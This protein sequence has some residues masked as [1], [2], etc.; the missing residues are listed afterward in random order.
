M[1]LI[2]G[3][4]GDDS[5]VGG[6]GSD[7]LLG[8]SGDDALNGGAGTDIL[9]G[10][11][12]DDVLNGGAGT[13][14]LYGGNGSDTLNGG[15]G[16]DLLDG[17]NGNDVLNGGTGND[18]LNGGNGND[19]LNG[20]SG[21]DIL[22]GQNG[23]DWLIY[24][25]SQ[26][27]G[28]SDYY[29]AGWGY[30]TLVLQLTYGELLLQSVQNDITAFRAFLDSGRSTAFEFSSFDLSA[31]GFEHLRIALLNNRPSAAADAAK[32]GEDDAVT[33]GVLAN[34]S[35][36]DHLD[37][38]TIA[39]LG[40]SK[41]GATI[42]Y[43]GGSLSYDPGSA[44]QWLAEGQVV[45]DTFS[46]TI[47]DLGGMTSTATV[48]V[49]VT[50]ENDAPTLM[51]ALSAA[52]AQPSGTVSEA[53]ESVEG[54][55]HTYGGT[56][57]FDD[58]DTL[59]THTASAAP[60]ASGY[61]GSLE[62]IVDN[63]A[64]TVAWSFTLDD[65][66]L[67]HL[68][69]N[70]VVSQFY[71]VIIDD[72]RAQVTQNVEI[73]LTGANDAPTI[74]ATRSDA[75]GTVTEDLTSADSGAIAF[76]DVDLMDL[77]HTVSFLAQG[78]GYRGLF[79]A[80]LDNVNDMVNWAFTVAPGELNDLAD[81]ELLTQLYSVIVDDGKGGS[82]AQTV[83][84]TLE[85]TNDA[86]DAQDD[87]HTVG[88]NA[89]AAIAV[90]ANDGDADGDTLTVTT[91]G[92]AAHG[93]AEINPDGTIRY[94]PDAGFYGADSFTYTVIDGKGGSDT[95]TVDVD[96]EAPLG[97]VVARELRFDLGLQYFMRAEGK[98]EWIELDSFQFGLS[99]PGGAETSGTD[100]T[101]VMSS[102]S[103]A[104][105]LF[106]AMSGGP[107]GFV[108]IEVYANFVSGPQLVDEFR[109]E[110]VVLTGHEVAGDSDPLNMTSGAQHSIWLSYAKIGHTLLDDDGAMGTTLRL[111]SSTTLAGPDA[112][113]EGLSGARETQVPDHALEF[114]LRVGD[115][116]WVPVKSYALGDGELTVTLGSSNALIKA[117]EYLASGASIESAEIEVYHAGRIVDEFKLD[118][119][120][121]T[122]LST[123]NA[124][125]F[126]PGTAGN[127][128][129]LG[130]AGIEYGHQ[131][132]GPEG[133]VG[134]FIGHQPSGDALAQVP[135]PAGM[136]Y[137]MR[138]TQAEAGP[139]GTQWI[140]LQEFSFGM[141]DSTDRE[142]SALELT[143]VMGA[144]AGAAKLL[145]AAIGS[146]PVFGSIEIE[147]YNGAMLVDE[148]KFD[149]VA[150]TGYD[151]DKGTV[152]EVSFGYRKLGHT[153]AETDTGMGWDFSAEGPSESPVELAQGM[154]GTKE[155]AAAPG[156]YFLKV[157]T[158]DG[159]GEWL[160]LA[161][162]SLGVRNEA[163]TVTL[164]DISVT[165]GSSNELVDLTLL[166][167]EGGPVTGAQIEVYREDG[168][169]IDEFVFDDV[170]LT[171]LESI[172]AAGNSLTF[173][174]ATFDYN[175][176][177]EGNPEGFAAPRAAEVAYNTSLQYFMKAHG[178]TDWI[179][180]QG[181][182]F[183]MERAG[184][185]TSMTDVAATMSTGSGAA[186]L[187]E[188]MAANG[189]ALGSIEIEAYQG[190]KL[191]DEFA[192][193]D[194]QLTRHE[195]KG[196]GGFQHPTSHS[197]SFDFAE[198]GHTHVG[199]EG[200]RS[201]TWDLE[202][203]TGD[204][205]GPAA[206][207]DQLVG[208]RD[209]AFVGNLNYYLR[210][211]GVG[212]PNEWLRLESY[213]LGL[214]TRDLSVDL[215][216]SR[217]LVELTEALG[218]GRQFDYAE[219]EAYRVVEG[220]QLIVDEFKFEDVVVRELLSTNATRNTLSFDYDSVSY[221]HAVSH[222]AYGEVVTSAGGHTPD[223]DIIDFFLA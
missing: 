18:V 85:G 158:A 177:T 191:V 192:F 2:T 1:S 223:G 99:H 54:G 62:A 24:N 97:G 142:T 7:I 77:E 26:N 86:P 157:D 116:A 179:P 19:T 91:L 17:G 172:N 119:V 190:G 63:D 138:A 49:T 135:L 122:G 150:V 195:A 211:E 145:Q 155:K 75:L 25:M 198:F 9:L 144:N 208:P 205:S 74:V 41:L 187:F 50:G 3:G 95:A 131:T 140:R 167:A 165:L 36:P 4:A 66:A 53:A 31:V 112:E 166:L 93:T 200:E 20:G 100:L 80:A 159:P 188:A 221:G 98:T 134:D 220:K 108:E 12:G 6:S 156:L 89:V 23:S 173:G 38:L 30:D 61:L 126:S 196:Q 68:A 123:E 148:Y 209:T 28:A 203:K 183:E 10:G 197:V 109:L 92:D 129:S 215:G 132:Y 137:F 5:L 169:L 96:V 185:T 117:T 43:N 149:G 154:S 42:A 32:T 106:A 29:D 161:S 104:A 193:Q 71:D 189:G 33:I 182:S 69:H 110:N 168:L 207:A 178:L 87:A 115:A 175:L 219:I 47:K 120:S 102:G 146:L 44:L 133:T 199:P 124:A 57:F 22:Y 72:G 35:D 171:G 202:S 213:E 186:K 51:S 11:N 81:K 79:T 143:A 107:I 164:E 163:G 40:A 8:G 70:Q 141:E 37:Y 162:Y 222:D 58:V 113:A 218:S 206:D 174:A 121:L 204:G 67:D 176:G 78:S 39:G 125:G 139:A 201:M 194:V 48:T 184:A 130:F 210:V 16:S 56:I 214:G 59:D 45:T 216:S 15:S 14:I 83:T 94:T 118:P 217:L 46:Y 181:F 152:H 170:V 105:K 153:H 82:A 127:T 151:V 27:L 21:S 84:I 101:A 111:G 64:D 136:Q 13:D 76:A 160:K 114:Y 55:S 88:H 60:Y 103:G 90:L 34:D 147:A 65:S 52:A 180:L 73:K 128:L 212:E